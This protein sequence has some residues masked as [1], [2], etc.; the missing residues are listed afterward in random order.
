VEPGGEPIEPRERPQRLDQV[1]LATQ[2]LDIGHAEP[3]GP[4]ELGLMPARASATSGSAG[5]SG[6]VAQVRSPRG[7][8]GVAEDPTTR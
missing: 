3:I 1:V 6:A 2:R 5:S 4:T 7:G 8:D